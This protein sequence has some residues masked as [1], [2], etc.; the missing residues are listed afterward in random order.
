MNST[1]STTRALDR[2]AL[3]KGTVHFARG[4]A[5]TSTFVIGLIKRR[6]GI[7]TDG[8]LLF[9]LGSVKEN[10]LFGARK[11]GITHNRKSRSR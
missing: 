5:K 3:Q 6:G 9:E 8:K 4:T 1:A 2:R 10:G 7:T 11:G